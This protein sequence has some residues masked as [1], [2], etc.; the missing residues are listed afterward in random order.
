MNIP[1]KDFCVGIYFQILRYVT[2]NGIAWSYSN[3]SGFPVG[4]M[5]TNSPAM[6]KVHVWSLGREDPLERGRATHSSCIAWRIPWTKNPGGLQSTGSQR[7]RHHLSDWVHTHTNTHIHT[8]THTHT[9]IILHSTF[10]GT[11][12]LFSKVIE[13]FYTP[14]EIYKVSSFSISSQTFSIIFFIITIL[15]SVLVVSY[16]GFDLHLTTD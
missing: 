14:T 11:D 2:R 8:H 6:H 15:V 9:H 1:I 4:S 3:S 16:C 5:V 10:W 13:L 12:K 7:V